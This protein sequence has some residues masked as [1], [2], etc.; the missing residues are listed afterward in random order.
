[1]P[2]K[3]D[4][5]RE[6]IRRMAEDYR[7]VAKLSGLQLEST[8]TEFLS[9]NARSLEFSRQFVKQ[10]DLMISIRDQLG[11]FERIAV[12]LKAMQ[13]SIGSAAVEQLHA[14]TQALQASRGILVTTSTFTEQARQLAESFTPALQLVD[15]EGLAEWAKFYQVQREGFAAALAFR[16]RDLP[17]REVTSV[18]EAELEA[19][20]AEGAPAGLIIQPF[21]ERLIRVDRLPFRV[22]RAVMADPRH[23]RRITAR[24]FEEFTAEILDA[25]GFKDIL[26]TPRSG[27]GGRDVIASRE[28]DGIPLTFYF[29]CKKY[30]EDNKVQLDSLRA[31]LGVVA[32]HATEANIGVLVT[33]S[34]FTAGAR[35]LIMSESR[36]DGKDYNDILGWVAAAK[37][38]IREV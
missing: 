8:V 2:T 20:T 28:V 30:A 37:D 24:Q 1:M 7:Q 35:R 17:L 21:R 27:D 18:P 14:A 22:L 6:L 32:H 33:T 38:R 15:R 10:A 5:P 36:L 11:G 34:T 25:L 19:V 16:I 26:L 23:L 4:D 13:G 3:S 31:L 12:E 29:E 9:A